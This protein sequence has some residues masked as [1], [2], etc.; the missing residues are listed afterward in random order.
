MSLSKT[1]ADV[2]PVKGFFRLRVGNV[3]PETRDA[4]AVTF[5]V[6]S[7]L[8]KQFAF[9]AGQ[10]LTLRKEI[11][12]EEI[13]RTYSICAATQDKILRIAIKRMPDGIFSS[14]AN[15][16]LTTGDYLDVMPP[17]GNFGVSLSL[18]HQRSYLAF[19]A[20]SGITPIFSIVKSAFMA[21]P[22]SSFPLFY[23]NLPTAPVLSS[24]ELAP[25]QHAL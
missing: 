14:W 12:G 7:V 24:D 17:A 25:L 2:P 9:A 1:I 21:Q 8:E 3:R 6:P 13:R 10:H 5:D 15:D 18:E 22:Q 16:R 11:D 23:A 4:I 19:A 20:G